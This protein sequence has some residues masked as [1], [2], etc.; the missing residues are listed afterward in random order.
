[1]VDKKI[2]VDALLFIFIVLGAYFGVLKGNVNI[3]IIALIAA[4]II[5]LFRRKIYELLP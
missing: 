5:S 2:V 4:L 3:A 1:M